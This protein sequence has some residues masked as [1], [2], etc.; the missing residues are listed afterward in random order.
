M[1]IYFNNI[2][3]LYKAQGKLQD[4]RLYSEQAIDIGERTLGTTSPGG[5]PHG[6]PRGA[7]RG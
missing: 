7:S 6:Q 3:L 5:H 2:A 1:A 4:A